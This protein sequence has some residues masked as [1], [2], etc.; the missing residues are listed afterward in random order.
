MISERGVAKV[1][2]L[3]LSIA[4]IQNVCNLRNIMLLNSGFDALRLLTAHILRE[5]VK[6]RHPHEHRAAAFGLEPPSPSEPS[7]CPCTKGLMKSVSS[8]MAAFSLFKSTSPIVSINCSLHKINNRRYMAEI[9]PI[10]RKTPYNQSISQ[11]IIRLINIF[12][13]RTLKIFKLFFMQF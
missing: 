12:L 10:R 6:T 8:L 11:S 5:S 7:N 2:V 4:P 1:R 9:L 13:S 3:I